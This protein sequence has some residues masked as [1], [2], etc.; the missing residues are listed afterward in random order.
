M[1]EVHILISSKIIHIVNFLS[2]LWGMDG[3]QCVMPI[4]RFSDKRYEAQAFCWYCHL[5]HLPR[6]L[7]SR[8]Y[9][10][11]AQGEKPN[12]SQVVLIGRDLCDQERTPMQNHPHTNNTDRQFSKDLLLTV[13]M[14]TQIHSGNQI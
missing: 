14:V 1:C 7:Y 3:G 9:S 12:S 13:S 6:Q 11:L 4:S 10:C 5:V 2:F 8:S